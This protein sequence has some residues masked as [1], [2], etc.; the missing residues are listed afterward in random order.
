MQTQWIDWLGVGSA[1]GIAALWLV[2]RYRR[3]ARRQRAA[4]GQLGACATGCAGCPF[5]KDCSGSKLH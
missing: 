2:L 4:A 1:V 5:A 3:N